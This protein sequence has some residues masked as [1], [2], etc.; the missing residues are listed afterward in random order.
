MTESLLEKIKEYIYL[1][2]ASCANLSNLVQ[3]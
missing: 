2:E 3:E 1:A